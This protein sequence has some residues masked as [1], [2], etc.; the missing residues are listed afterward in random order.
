M[1]DKIARSQTREPPAIPTPNSFSCYP[2]ACL[3]E[4]D[5]LLLEEDEEEEED[6][7]PSRSQPRAAMASATAARSGRWRRS[8]SSHRALIFGRLQ[9]GKYSDLCFSR[10]YDTR[11]SHRA[12]ISGRLHSG[13]LPKLCTRGL[14]PE[15]GSMI[16]RWGR[17]LHDISARTAQTCAGECSCWELLVRGK[18]QAVCVHPDARE[19]AEEQ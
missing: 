13:R 10:V 9:N 1:R 8:A 2:H 11:V 7:V 18:A 5:P 3:L 12:L 15:E 17:A 14:Q 19:V 4:D 16:N 6:E